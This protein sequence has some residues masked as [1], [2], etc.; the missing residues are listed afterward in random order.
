[1]ISAMV[2][3]TKT[4]IW[5]AMKNLI[6]RKLY[7]INRRSGAGI[8]FDVAEYRDFM[9][10]QWLANCYSVT[11]SRLRFV[12]RHYNNLPQVFYRL[13]EIHNTRSRHTIIV[14]NKD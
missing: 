11:H 9:Q 13:Y 14:C 3:S 8:S 7:A 6:N 10:T 4:Q 12:R 2:N 5:F 1:M